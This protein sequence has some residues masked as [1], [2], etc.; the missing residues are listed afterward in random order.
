MAAG[1]SRRFGG[2][3]L[4]T[5]WQGK[6]LIAYALE[7]VPAGVE[8]VVVSQYPE[9][10]SLA[11][12][13]GFLPRENNRPQD[14]IS[15]TIRLGLEALGNCDGVLFLVADQPRL[16]RETVERLL[17]LWRAHPQAIVGLTANR[18]QGNPILF[19][20]DLFPELLALEGDTGGRQ[21]I[22]RHPDRLLL[23]E[24]SEEELEDIDFPPVP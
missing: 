12:E 15:R 11:R 6:P 4:L 22:R 8:T 1:S 18:H 5:D 19:P 24:A 3:K 23:L 21:V 9:I 10:L 2:N 17:D 16:R 7:A 13:C 14:G 20:A